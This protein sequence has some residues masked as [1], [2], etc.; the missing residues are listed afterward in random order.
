MAG[1]PHL[2]ERTLNDGGPV[3]ELGLRRVNWV[4]I[5]MDDDVPRCQVAGV[6]HRIPVRRT[7]PLRTAV[8]LIAAG[9]PYTVR[10]GG[11]TSEVAGHP[12]RSSPHGARV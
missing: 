1:N 10:R 6:G 3:P 5:V 11:A 2:R 8:A 4:L 9:T 12:A 7:V